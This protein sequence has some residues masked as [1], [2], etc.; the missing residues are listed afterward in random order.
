MTGSLCF[1]DAEG[2]RMLIN[3]RP[4][5][6]GSAAESPYAVWSRSLNDAEKKPGRGWSPVKSLIACGLRWRRPTKLT[7]AK[8]RA[9]LDPSERCEATTSHSIGSPSEVSRRPVIAVQFA[10]CILRNSERLE[11]A[12]IPHFSCA[13][14]GTWFEPRVAAF[15][16]GPSAVA[17][18]QTIRRTRRDKADDG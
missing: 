9:I 6:S 14:I 1:A 13:G 12:R 10:L 11:L 17:Q 15:P 16:K 8:R 2:P 5:S 18:S 4:R 7:E 3:L